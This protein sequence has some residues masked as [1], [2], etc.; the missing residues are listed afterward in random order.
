MRDRD[1]MNWS[2][3]LPW[4]ILGVTVRIHILFPCVALGYIL[5]VGTSKQF[6][7]GLWMQACVVLVILFI[8]VLLH[9]MGHVIGARR[10]DGDAM[11]VLLWPLGGLAYVDVPHTPRAN[12]WSTLAGPLVNGVLAL[13]G[14]LG[15]VAVGFIP[16]WNPLESPLTPKVH[17]WKQGISYSGRMN[18][19]DDEM[20]YYQESAQDQPPQFRQ[21]KISKEWNKDGSSTVHKSDPPVETT[22]NGD[23][24][25]SYVLKD[26]KQIAVKAA[27]L[28]K[29]QMLLVQFYVVNFFLLAVNLL[30]AF[31]LDGGRLLQCYL[32]RR[33]DYRRATESAAWIGFLIM[34]LVG[35]YAIAVNDILPAGLAVM[36]YIMCRQQL[37]QLEHMEEA[38]SMGYDFSQGYTSLER[39]E[40]PPPQPKPKPN[41]FQRMR[42]QWSERRAKRDQERREAEERRL[43]EI[44]EKIHREGK[45]ALTPEEQRFL[46]RLSNR[47]R[48]EK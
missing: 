24:N 12:F 27:R 28:D 6:A 21:V 8:S 3:P 10:V 30:P 9:E 48:T 44:L 5:W 15:L 46:Q 39:E 26:R 16:P 20:Y 36:I 1:P 43:D 45:Q 42:Q 38:S 40:D 29:W 32:W 13:A 31:P 17:N 35:I 41:W 2:M 14:G 25:E 4:P 37:M 18:P 7:P 33:T 22:T 19:G 34:L 47:N 23:Q 11:E